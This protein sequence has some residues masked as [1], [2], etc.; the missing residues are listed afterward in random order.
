[1]RY[2]PKVVEHFLA[3]FGAEEKTTVFEQEREMKVAGLRPG[4]ILS[5]DLIANNNIPLLT[6]GKKIN[7]QLIEKLQN[8]ENS[9]GEKLTVHIKVKVAT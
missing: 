9:L 3:L 4:M 5:K 2:H 1:M 6:K 7:Q 8:Y